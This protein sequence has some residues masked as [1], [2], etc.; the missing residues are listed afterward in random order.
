MVNLIEL[1]YLRRHG[2]KR[3]QREE[4]IG[5]KK[6]RGGGLER[7]EGVE[8]VEGVKPPPGGPPLVGEEEEEEETPVSR[9]FSFS[10]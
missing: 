7:V 10:R 3:W 6:E 2:G 4:G 8:G 9:L 5:R 1:N